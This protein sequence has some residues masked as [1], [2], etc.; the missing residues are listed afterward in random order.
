MFRKLNPNSK[1]IYRPISIKLKTSKGKWM[2]NSKP[3][4]MTNKNALPKSE[5]LTRKIK[6]RASEMR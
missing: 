5:D 1:G 2:C 6:V 3:S 4:E